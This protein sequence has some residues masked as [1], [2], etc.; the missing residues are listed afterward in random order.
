M[1]SS[2]A[3]MIFSR[4]NYKTRSSSPYL[5]QT[6]ILLIRSTSM[7]MGVFCRDCFAWLDYINY[8]HHIP[9]AGLN[10]M[11]QLSLTELTLPKHTVINCI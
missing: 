7:S 8:L 4:D 2:H 3:V 1:G 5:V 10:T 6:H 9:Q 11:L